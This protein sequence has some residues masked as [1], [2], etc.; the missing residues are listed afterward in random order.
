M[1]KWEKSYDREKCLN[2]KTCT[3]GRM[4]INWIWEQYIKEMKNTN[5]GSRTLVFYLQTAMLGKLLISSVMIQGNRHRLVEELSDSIHVMWTL[6]GWTLGL[7]PWRM[8]MLL[9]KREHRE[10]SWKRRREMRILIFHER[11]QWKYPFGS[12]GKDSGVWRIDKSWT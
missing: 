2:W 6:D 3:R 12:W 9:S 10:V 7:D 1:G 5:L 8:T 11:I 4:V